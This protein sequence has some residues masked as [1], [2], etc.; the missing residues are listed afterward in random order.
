MSLISSGNVLVGTCSAIAMGAAGYA[1]GGSNPLI[2]LAGT[3]GAVAI[4]AIYNV[5]SFSW[6]EV[7]EEKFEP[8]HVDYENL[9]YLGEIK[10]RNL[11][12][13]TAIQS[14]KVCSFLRKMDLKE[15]EVMKAEDV[16][17]KKASDLTKPIIAGGAT[18][19]GIIATV[20]WFAWP[21]TWV[22]ETIYVGA[23]TL[24]GSGV[25]GGMTGLVVYSQRVMSP[26][27]QMNFDR[28]NRLR[29]KIENLSSRISFLEK[30]WGYPKTLVQL[31]VARGSFEGALQA[32]SNK[33][34][35]HHV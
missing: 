13:H 16:V 9:K 3:V 21:I 20:I 28:S 25:M 35:V 10:N 27:E 15:Y 7:P 14:S 2:A 18:A 23:A 11:F 32:Y 33:V 6:S 12:A 24:A 30:K 34:T 8:L 29:S 31:R 4:T 22:A 5:I 19:G 1:L 26:M 17:A